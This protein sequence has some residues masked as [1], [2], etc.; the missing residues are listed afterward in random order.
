MQVRDALLQQA[1]QKVEG[2]EAEQLWAA[3]SHS[4]GTIKPWHVQMGWK[5]RACVNQ[6]VLAPRVGGI[7][8]ELLGVDSV[9]LY[10]DNA[11]SRCPGSPRTRWHCDDGPD[12]HMAMSCRNVVT[13][14][15]PLQRT[16]P[17]M[18][19]LA[20]APDGAH[21]AWSVAEMEGCPPDEQSDTYDAFVASKLAESS[22]G[23]DCE[24]SQQQPAESHACV[25]PYIC[26]RSVDQVRRTI[27]A[28]SACT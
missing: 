22:G 11:L 4:G 8:S 16:T 24:H 1:G 13:V 7:V 2:L 14:W 9:R 19:A 10:H 20:F 28:I 5:L 27:W 26:A 12:K 21:D 15:V 3:C 18:G 23:P 25:S 6:L 17:E